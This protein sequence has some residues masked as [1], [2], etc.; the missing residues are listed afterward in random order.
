MVGFWKHLLGFRRSVEVGKAD[1]GAG[2][3]LQ[4]FLSDEELER[5]YESG[6]RN[7]EVDR[8]FVLLQ[9]IEDAIK[10][11]D[12]QRAIGAG[13]ASL[14]LL[15][16]L[17]RD[18]VNTSGT[19]R[20]DIQSIPAI[21]R[22][23]KVAL[24]LSDRETLDAMRQEVGRYPAL[25]AWQALVEA[26]SADIEGVEA[27]VSLVAESPGVVQLHLKGK[28]SPESTRLQDL[29]AWMEKVG[30]IRREKSGKSYKLFSG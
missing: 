3:R 28:F 16:E 17:V 18:T 11:G 29:C 15:G 22:V 6:F 21:D 23:G 8:Y 12:F 20:F 4:I 1:Q 2:D 7:R 30:R 9:E 19:A 5:Q 26:M 24:A 13:R 25:E 14:P 10:R 27:I